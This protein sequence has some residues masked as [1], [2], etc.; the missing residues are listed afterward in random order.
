VKTTGYC[1]Q[2]KLKVEFDGE[3]PRMNV[4]ARR[5]VKGRCPECGFPIQRIMPRDK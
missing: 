4:A 5:V 2:C 1:V 3:E